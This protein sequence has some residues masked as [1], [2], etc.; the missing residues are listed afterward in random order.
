[1]STNALELQPAAP[2]AEYVEQNVSMVQQYA[3]ARIQ[4]AYVM[5]TRAPRNIELVRQ[6]VLRECSR[7]SFCVP[8]ESK[9]GSSLAIYRV[10][11][12]SV[13]D[14]NGK[15]VK[16]FIQGP[17]IRFAE[18]LLRSYRNLS[19]EVVPVGEDSDQ[20]LL[21]VILTD[22]Q[23]CNWT[24]EQV[25]IPKRVERKNAKPDDVIIGQ[26]TNSYGNTIFIVQATDDELQMKTNALVSKARRNLILQA[27]PGWL[28]EEGVDRVRATA[29]NKDAEDPDAAKRKLFDAFATVGVSAAQLAEYLGHANALSPAELEDLRGL[30]SG[31]KEGFTTWGA[32]MAAK[33]DEG[34]DDEETVKAIED[35]IKVLELPVARVRKLK[36]QYAGQPLAK[37]LEWLQGEVAKKQQGQTAGKQEPSA[38]NPTGRA[39][40]QQQSGPADTS[41]TAAST[42]T[43][44][45]QSQGHPSSQT[46]QSPQATE[47]LDA[48][49][50]SEEEAAAY[51][52]WEAEEKAKQ[53][54]DTK[55]KPSPATTRP[56]TMPAATTRGG[57]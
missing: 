29:R 15:W 40:E 51:A 22:Y 12:G 4:S 21:Q 33:K 2:I 52:K 44:S 26:R 31:I 36:G 48:E 16:Q 28:I 23:A 5:A 46:S 37:L 57:W 42:Q 8:D 6:E 50:A 32:V 43:G 54:Q 53:Q 45:T 30:Y 49:P 27:V 13:Q 34:G 1:M 17:T 47:N 14:A 24:S 39:V 41:K 19:I 7:P 20:I 18:M 9:F 25:R 38:A 11:R 55:P 3:T 10:P 35:A 56:K